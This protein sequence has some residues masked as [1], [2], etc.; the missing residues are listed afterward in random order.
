MDL[1][2]D[3][4]HSDH[5]KI[6]NTKC[7][8]GHPLTEQEYIEFED[9]QRKALDEGRDL[10]DYIKEKYGRRYCCVMALMTPVIGPAKLTLS[11]ISSRILSFDTDTANEPSSRGFSSNENA[12]Q[13]RSR[14]R[15]SM[16]KIYTKS[17]PEAVL[18]SQPQ[19]IVRGVIPTTQ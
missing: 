12:D 18:E 13:I 3:A 16:I 10:R 1:D 8:Q 19:Y 11:K 14:V 6:P 4:T 17:V 2:V 15:T 9:E 5:V 7:L